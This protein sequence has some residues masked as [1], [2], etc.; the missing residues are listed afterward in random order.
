MPV[1]E[2]VRRLASE[3]RWRCPNR[4]TAC[5]GDQGALPRVARILPSRSRASRW[6]KPRSHPHG[7]RGPHGRLNREFAAGF[8]PPGRRVNCSAS[9]RPPF[10]PL[11]GRGMRCCGRMRVCGCKSG[12]AAL[13]RAMRANATRAAQSRATGT[14]AD[15]GL[16]QR[17]LRPRAARPCRR[18]TARPTR[19]SAKALPDDAISPQASSQRRARGRSAPRGSALHRRPAAQFCAMAPSCAPA[20]PRR[21]ARCTSAALR[22]RACR[23]VT[24]ADIAQAGW[25]PSARRLLPWQASDFG[26]DSGPRHG[27]RALRRRAVG[28]C[29]E[30]LPGADAADA[31][32]WDDE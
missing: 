7:L 4:R 3:G 15:L 31:C 22:C 19:S 30:P 14:S 28:W 9:T 6:R 17:D 5:G 24:A 11:R 2:A 18:M 27:A 26:R 21:F 10:P 20:R 8:A 29:R 23:V 12:I 16:R 1:R 25:A 13:S 32:R